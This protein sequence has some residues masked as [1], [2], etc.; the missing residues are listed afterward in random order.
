MKPLKS[1]SLSNGT[2]SPTTRTSLKQ[3]QVRV[4]SSPHTTTV[5]LKEDGSFYN[6]TAET[7]EATARGIQTAKEHSWNQARQLAR[8]QTQ[9]GLIEGPATGLVLP[10]A[11]PF[12]TVER[13]IQGGQIP[14]GYAVDGPVMGTL[15][16]LLSTGVG[17]APKYGKSSALRYIVALAL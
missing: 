15:D 2:L 11:P 7:A 14:L 4:L 8:L 3:A 13:L 6:P 12:S 5:F 1:T 16:D 17:G 10:V 9:Q